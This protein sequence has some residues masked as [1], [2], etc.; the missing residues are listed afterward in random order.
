MTSACWIYAKHA[1]YRNSGFKQ[2][3]V[4]FRQNNT[5]GILGTKPALFLR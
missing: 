1:A 2:I 4:L 3:T 5:Q